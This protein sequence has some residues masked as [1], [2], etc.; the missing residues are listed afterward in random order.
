[1]AIS[2]FSLAWNDSLT[3][4]EVAHIPAGYSYVTLHDYRLNPE[5]PPLLKV[6]SGLFLLPL[7][8]TFDVYDK[9]FWTE[10][11]NTGEYGQWEAGRYLLHHAGNNTDLIVFFARMPIVILSICFG[12]FL[13][14]WGKKLGGI[15]TGLLTLIFYAFDPNILGHNH[16]VTTDIGIAAAIGIALYFF[17]QFL[18]KP[19]WSYALYGGIALGVAQITKF[20]AVMLIPIFGVFLVIYP[21]IKF[22]P[23]DT[24]RIKE[25]FLYLVK[26]IYALL[27]MFIFIWISYIPVTYHMPETVLPPIAAV[28][29]QPEKYP[30]DE[31]F[32][33]FINFA[34]ASPLTRP[35]ATYTQGLMQ[36]LNR[37]NDG[38]VTYFL[39]NVS[40][41]ASMMY[42]PF[43]FVAK[44][45]LIHIF[46]YTVA[47]MLFALLI[48][49]STR[50]FFINTPR[51]ALK[52]FRAFVVYRFHEIAL[53][54]FIIFYSYISI[55]G[56][57]NIGFRHLFPMMPL[58]YLLTAK[59]IVGSYK[60]LRNI[61]RKRLV[62]AVFIT[63]IVLLIFIVLHAYPYYMSYF[64]MLF[65]GP[66]NGYHFVTD[67][68][69]DWGQ[70]LK[71]LR[72]YL[73]EHPEIGEIRVDYFGGDN[74]AHRI[75]EH[76]YISWWSSKRP[77]EPGY[78]AISTLLL[79]E[80]IFD[81]MRPDDDSYR[82]T[83]DHK[84]IDQVGTSIV[85]IKI[86]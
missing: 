66:K 47:L 41:D 24:N 80:S 64:N 21:L 33:T 55:T 11:Y 65:G 51:N 38:N 25:F 15:I 19:T 85:I 1:M 70:D 12:I 31:Y 50:K 52:K 23:Q 59:T 44:Q 76:R 34:N 18:K 81:P 27:I 72:S 71:R 9:E 58:I 8:L 49:R 74:V 43:V 46:F 62:R 45:T 7:D 14:F 37:V 22:L 68:N 35:I 60:S 42:F 86:D 5:H 57:L 29:G 48:Y 67:S 28:K 4:D 36:V 54:S 75:G 10:T 16:Y 3:F 32:I 53:L 20:S 2:S 78:Y 13:F 6:L 39:G 30:Q 83:R 73:D 61:R 40:S 69:A 82:W 79:Q 84:I 17:L 63:L 56:N 77:I 26:G